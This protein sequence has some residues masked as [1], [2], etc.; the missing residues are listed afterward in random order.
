MKKNIVGSLFLKGISIIVQLML[1]PL[2]LGYVSS[3]LYGIWLTLSSVILWLNFFDI[4]FTLGLKN[5]LGEAIALSQWERGKTLVS[6]TYFMMCI[7]FVPLFVV[8]VL[9]VPLIDW[10][11]FLNVNSSY[12]AS[13]QRAMY[14]LS[15]C[16]C[17]QMI[18]NVLTA[19][20]SAY[21]KVALSS[22]FYVGGNLLSL[23]TIFILTK[24]CPPSLEALALAVSVMP[25]IVTTIS[26]IILFSGKFK[27]V[28]PSVRYIDKA[29]IK[30]LFSLG[31]KFFI[32]QI[33][34][35]IMTQSAN[36]LISNLSGP[37]DVTAYNIAQKYTSVALMLFNIIL[38]PL[39]PAFTDAYTR[40]DFAWMKNI[41]AKMNKICLFSTIGIVLMVAISPFVYHLWI[42]NKAE[43]PFI[44]TLLVAL[45]TIICSWQA[46]HVIMINGI[47][48]VKLQTYV[49]LA[50]M[51]LHIPFSLLLGIYIGGY[52][53][54]VS[55]TLITTVY[56]IFFSIQ[57]HRI[58]NQKAN[59]I[60]IK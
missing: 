17:L 52:G 12:N 42:G 18:V 14:I 21:Q 53:V 24:C 23:I 11:S 55:M 45:Y 29:Y 56:L 26:S 54:I 30:D 5:K 31:V 37:N 7:I 58:L 47:G 19:V 50:G 25:I 33:Q 8:L 49:T 51:L 46:L 20:V 3:E 27:K 38:S 22:V 32:I 60:W 4:G 44:M 41:Y 57:L 35:V 39:W 34:V 15:A 59:G 16:F 1:V 6:T 40:K 10:A 2:T 48:T 36:F 43:I 13:I 28:A 9:L